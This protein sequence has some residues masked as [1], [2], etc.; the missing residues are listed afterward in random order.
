MAHDRW[1]AGPADAGIRLD[2][3]LAAPERVGSRGKAFVWH[4]PALEFARHYGFALKACDRADAARKGKVERPFA[5]L[6]G[7]FLPRWTSTRPPTSVS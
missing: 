1:T 2:K 4:A 6:K 3:F 5:D 7:G